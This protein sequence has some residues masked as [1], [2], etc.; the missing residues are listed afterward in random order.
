MNGPCKD[1]T[2]NLGV[3]RQ[4]V[5]ANPSFANLPSSGSWVSAYPLKAM[6]LKVSLFH[7]IGAMPLLPHVGEEGRSGC[8]FCAVWQRRALHCC[9]I[10][11]SLCLTMKHRVWMKA[12]QHFSSKLKNHWIGHLYASDPNAMPYG[13]TARH[14]RPDLGQFPIWRQQFIFLESCRSWLWAYYLQ[15]QSE[16]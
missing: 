4:I 6:Q 10:N 3:I 7:N 9:H 13:H 14:P 5:S 16:V 1:W 2:H 11:P 8:G 12:P 15:M